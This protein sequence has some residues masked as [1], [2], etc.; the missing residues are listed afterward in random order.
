MEIINE[1]ENDDWT[2]VDN[3][4]R[5]SHNQT[6][7]QPNITQLPT[8]PPTVHPSASN[9]S[10]N[11]RKLN[12]VD[13]PYSSYLRSRG[14][15]PYLR[16]LQ[17]SD[18]TLTK[19][20]EELV[21]KRLKDTICC[22]CCSDTNAISKVI[23]RPFSACGICYCCAGDD[24]MMCCDDLCVFVNNALTTRFIFVDEN[25]PFKHYSINK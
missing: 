23:K 10:K 13:T 1:N 20:E 18:Y 14:L 19:N 4:N 15:P 12:R 16:P 17:K 25:S 5:K 24:E 8:S 21:H 6:S 22:Y 7:K 3:K 9:A 11:K 2:L